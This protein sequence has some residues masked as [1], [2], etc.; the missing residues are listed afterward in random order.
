MSTIVQNENKSVIKDEKQ[1]PYTESKKVTIK[2]KPLASGFK[3]MNKIQFED[4][5]CKIGASFRNNDT[6]R[7]L[8][9]EEEIRLLPKIIGTQPSSDKWEE[10]TREYWNNI[11]KNIPDNGLQLETGMMWLSK[12]D[13]DAD[14]RAPKDEN[15][16]IIN[17]KGRP[18]NTADYI[19][20]RYCLLYSECANHEKDLHKAPRIRMYIHSDEVERK[21]KKQALQMEM[22]ANQLFYSSMAD[23]NWARWLLRLL[24]TRDTNIK[25]KI[26]V[27]H[28]THISDDDVNF[29][30]GDYIKKDAELFFVLGNDKDLH[31]KAFIEECVFLGRLIRIANTEAIMF[32]NETIGHTVDQTVA[33]LND[34]KNSRV[35]DTLKAQININR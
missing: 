3:T 9:P 13:Y 33:F 34:P 1:F 35:L 11:S 16:T 25:K 12:E 22:K 20:H 6:L 19:I 21:T 18:I 31:L 8:T 29:G 26:T 7:G 24:V 32:D 17:S 10:K 28:L 27:G 15:G 14:K 23:R 5:M 30:L 4:K 2:R